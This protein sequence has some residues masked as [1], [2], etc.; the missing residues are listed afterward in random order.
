MDGIWAPTETWEFIIQDYFNGAG[1]PSSAFGSIGVTST[2]GGIDP[3]NTSSGSILVMFDDHLVGGTM[4]PI[5][6]TALVIA[7]FNANSIWMIPTVL[8]LVGAGIVIYKL[9]RK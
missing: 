2:F 1:A 4:I 8:G 5:D 3:G 6:T 9:K 7:G